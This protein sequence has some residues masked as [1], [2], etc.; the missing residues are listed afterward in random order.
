MSSSALDWRPILQVFCI[1][2]CESCSLLHCG[3]TRRCIKNFFFLWLMLGMAKHS[4]TARKRCPVSSVWECF[5]R[6][7]DVC[8]SELCTKDGGK[9]V[10]C[11]SLVLAL[12]LCVHG[13]PVS[14][15]A[16]QICS[17]SAPSWSA[18][19]VLSMR[20][21]NIAARNRQPVK[22]P[23]ELSH[24]CHKPVKRL[25]AILRKNHWNEAVVVLG[26]N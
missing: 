23:N 8:Y 3:W 2:S 22:S 9:I 20:S 14:S 1:H 18:I 7:E 4:S 13:L 25:D 5:W 11:C 10:D 21:A 19:I 15:R 26:T 24:I 17:K 16:Q 6:I 12:I